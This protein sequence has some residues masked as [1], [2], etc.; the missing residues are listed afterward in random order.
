[1]H[2]GADLVEGRSRFQCR[3]RRR[4]SNGIAARLSQQELGSRIG[5]DQCRDAGV[6]AELSSRTRAEEEI[7]LN[8]WAASMD[9]A[10]LTYADISRNLTLRIAHIDLATADLQYRPALRRAQRHRYRQ[11]W[12]SREQEPQRCGRAHCL[13]RFPDR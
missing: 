7:A 11:G 1:S 2:G 3:R 8:D 13:D 5:M 10:V 6:A 12:V 4:G 9:F